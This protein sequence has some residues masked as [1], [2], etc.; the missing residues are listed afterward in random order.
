[1]KVL[2]NPKTDNYNYFKSIVL[3]DELSW[4]YIQATCGTAEV[5]NMFGTS[6]GSSDTPFFSSC[7]LERP[8]TEQRYP[9]PNCSQKILYLS[10][11][12]IDEILRANEINCECIFRINMNMTI[13][14][15]ENQSWS[16]KHVDHPFPHKNLLIYFNTPKVGGELKVFNNIFTHKE[17]DE[18]DWECGFQYLPTEDSVVLF[19]G[20][21][22][23]S[24]Q[25]PTS[26]GER[27]IVMVVTFM[28][29]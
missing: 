5:S 23:H 12:V 15:P 1:M 18:P 14:M 21:H 2:T 16:P 29:G 27:R 17:D 4:N 8:K 26:L 24:S 11:V 13:G 25:S 22:F 28:E 7:I 9:L 10:T 3:G 20:K 19:D 6:W